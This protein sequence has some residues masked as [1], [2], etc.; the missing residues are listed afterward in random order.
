MHVRIRYTLVYIHNYNEKVWEYIFSVRVGVAEHTP[1][2]H[3]CHR[4][5]EKKRVFDSPPPEH[6][7]HLQYQLLPS[8]C[9]DGSSTEEDGER[10]M[11]KSDVVTFGVI[12]KVYTEKDSRV[13]R[14]WEEEGKEDQQP[15]EEDG[16]DHNEQDKE[17][18]RSKKRTHF[19]WRHK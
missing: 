19:G 6:Y 1:Q 17:G 7:F 10:Q 11:S 12:S 18:K 14:C 2:F 5:G 13:L 16:G 9:S 3:Y 15:G 8:T 4:N